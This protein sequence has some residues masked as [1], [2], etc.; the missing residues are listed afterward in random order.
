MSVTVS[1]GSLL[2]FL[3][4]RVDREA[5][6]TDPSRGVCLVAGGIVG[7][8]LD[9]ALARREVPTVAIDISTIEITARTLLDSHH[10]RQSDAPER[11][12][13]ID[14]PLGEALVVDAITSAPDSAELDAVA[15]LLSGL[16]DASG[17]A[18]ARTRSLLPAD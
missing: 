13:I 14:Q 1:Y 6:P 4:A 5:D 2:S 8:N 16:T 10:R 3:D 9:T 18:V 11:V 15:D 12:E 17:H 7:D